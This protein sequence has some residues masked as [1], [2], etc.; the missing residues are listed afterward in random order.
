MDINVVP[1]DNA[2][3]Y[4]LYS[5][6]L[7]SLSSLQC[8]IWDEVRTATASDKDIF[9]L[10]QFIESGISETRNSLP[11]SLREYHQFRD[12]LSTVDGVAIYKNRIVVPPQGPTLTFFLT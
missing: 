2:G 4:V 3:E 8:V 9:Q 7:S 11:L 1:D 6:A 5:F 12:H 10:V